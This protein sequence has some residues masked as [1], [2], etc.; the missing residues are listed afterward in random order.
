MYVVCMSKSL[1]E[2]VNMMFNLLPVCSHFFFI[3]LICLFPFVRSTLS[4]TSSDGKRDHA[5]W[6]FLLRSL[7]A[8]VG[9]NICGR[10]SAYNKCVRHF[11]C[12]CS[13][14]ACVWIK[15]IFDYLVTIR[16]KRPSL[17]MWDNQMYLSTSAF[18]TIIKHRTLSDE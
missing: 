5:H 8:T 16:Y 1:S 9:K 4:S 15:Q 11:E 3:I 7:E 2:L 13:V 17:R 14:C 18:P 10:T 6:H 12:L